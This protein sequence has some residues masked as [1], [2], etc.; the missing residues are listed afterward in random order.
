MPA[1]EDEG[2]EEVINEESEVEE[3]SDDGGSV[4][5]EDEDELDDE[6][7]DGPRFLPGTKLQVRAPH[8]LLD[9]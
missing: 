7:E 8:I 1:E 9:L 2:E 6:Y 3:D 5:E 4:C